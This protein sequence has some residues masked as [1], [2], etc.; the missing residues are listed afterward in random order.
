M[1]WQQKS[2]WHMESDTG[3]K[4]SKGS[5]SAPLPYGAWAPNSKT[6]TPAI[7]Y[8]KT[9]KQAMAMCEKHH[10]TTGAKP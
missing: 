4:I 3:H 1:E 10:Q 5:K 6:E 2:T 7:G 9:A 8:A